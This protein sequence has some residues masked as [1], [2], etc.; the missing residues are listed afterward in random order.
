MGG[1]SEAA[2]KSA[3]GHI[4]RVIGLTPL[5]FEE[6][7]ALLKEVEACLNPRP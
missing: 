3:K 1:L 7:C 4:Q 5:N 6:F 2:V